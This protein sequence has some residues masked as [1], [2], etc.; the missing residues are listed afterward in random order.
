[1]ASIWGS[2][3]NDM[4]ELNSIDYVPVTPGDVA[5]G[6]FDLPVFAVNNI[7]WKGAS[8][9][10]KQYG[11]TASKNFALRQRPAKPSGAN[12]VPCIR[13]RIGDVVYRWKL[14]EDANLV[15]PNVVLYAGQIIK[16]NFCIEIWNL[17]GQ[18]T[19]GQAASLR[20]NAGIRRV[21]SDF[22]ALPAD[23]ADDIGEA[24]ASLVGTLAAGNPP[25]GATVWFKA[26][27]GV[28]KAGNNVTG[29][30]DQSGN[31][32]NLANAG[33]ASPVFF[34]NG[35][36]DRSMPYIFFDFTQGTLFNLTAPNT[37]CY[38]IALVVDTWELGKTVFN[39]G[40][41]FTTMNPSD[42]KLRT[43]WLVNAD[44]DYA[45]VVGKPLI[46]RLDRT[47]IPQSANRVQIVRIDDYPT[48]VSAAEVNTGGFTSAQGA[49]IVLG[50]DAGLTY[51]FRIAELIGYNQ[52]ALSAANDT[53]I[54]EYFAA[55]YA[56]LANLPIV[57]DAGSPWLDNP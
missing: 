26:D 15:L 45:T 34:A 36:S 32:Y 49:V 3:K 17:N 47:N 39:D 23:Y 11:F 7:A 1:M 20:L 10:V 18:A 46:L 5:H 2:I 41:R 56:A 13:Y 54:K 28:T 29:W 4:P 30:A 12:Y 38:Y 21:I 48:V 40:T 51:Q 25:A 55:R 14:W 57:L 53:A 31:G 19:A 37:Q 6:Y 22:S 50:G 43:N 44:V 52:A 9:I 35:F 8:E 42:K 16:K 33:F 24:V 27:A